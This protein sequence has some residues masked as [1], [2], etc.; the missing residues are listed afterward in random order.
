MGEQV[1]KHSWNREL[2]F[3]LQDSRLTFDRDNKQTE[4][5]TPFGKLWMERVY[6]ANCGCDGGLVTPDWAQH[7]FY[8]CEECAHKYGAMPPSVAEVPEAVVRGNGN[9]VEL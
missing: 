9:D 4:A 8:L 7:V 3:G 2:E 6:C 1:T 5:R